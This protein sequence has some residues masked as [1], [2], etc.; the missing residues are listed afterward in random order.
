MADSKTGK[1]RLSR[2]RILFIIKRRFLAQWSFAY[3]QIASKFIS[4][5]VSSIYYY[6]FFSSYY[7]LFLLFLYL[8]IYYYLLLL[9]L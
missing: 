4:Q 2:L 3:W 8:R 1:P 9:F 6:C 7:Y 5:S